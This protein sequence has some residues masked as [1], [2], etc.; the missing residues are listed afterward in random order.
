MMRNETWVENADVFP[1]MSVP[2]TRNVCWPSGS[3]TV[4][5]LSELQLTSTSS[6]LHVAA[7]SGSDAQASV[8]VRSLAFECVTEG[9]PNAGFTGVAEGRDGGIRLD[10]ARRLLQH[11][12]RSH[13]EGAPGPAEEHPVALRR[14][15]SDELD[16]PG[17]NA[18]PHCVV[19]P[20]ITVA[21][22]VM[23]PPIDPEPTRLGVTWTKLAEADAA[24]TP[25]A[26]TLTMSV[27]RTRTLNTFLSR[28][29]PN[30]SP[31][32]RAPA[33]TVDQTFV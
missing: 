3:V 19:V 8:T 13:G 9:V 30:T 17:N 10:D 20:L 1:A 26:M 32:H 22:Q 21:L 2:R 14:R 31:D 5:E 6:T 23:T 24:L 33:A 29:R 4:C 15:R 11:A 27:I 18:D 28:C 7:R 12:R 16:R 25:Q